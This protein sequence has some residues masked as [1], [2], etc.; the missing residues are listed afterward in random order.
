MKFLLPLLWLVAVTHAADWPQFLGPTR[1]NVSTETNLNLAWPKEGPKILWKTKIGEGWSGPV[2]VSNCVMVFHRVGDSEVLDCFQNTNGAKLW[3]AE[4]PSTYRDDFGFESGPRATPAVDGQRVF[5]F[6]ANGILNAWNLTNGSNLWRVDTRK[7]FSS[8]KGF[9]GIACSPLVEGGAVI[10]NIGG[11]G[12]GVVSFDQATGKV[13]WQTT[14]EEAS[15]SSPTVATIGGQRRIF[16]FGRKHLLALDRDGKLLWEFP[17]TPRIEASVSA[18]TPLVIGEQVFISAS[19]G[20]GAALL[21]VTGARPEVVW[22]GDDSL[23]SHYSSIVHQRG[24]LYGFD[25]RQEQR[26]RLRCVELATGKARWSEER[27][28]AGA[29]LVVGDRLLILTERGELIV[30]PASQEKFSPTA[31]AQILGTDLRAHPALADG[32]FF[33]RDK[34]VLVAVDLRGRP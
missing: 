14:S 3:H 31:R 16:V 30:V 22:S 5:T 23:S 7:Q 2:V 18:A 26:A 11:T 10:L 34:G 4:Y 21:R 6:G 12:A 28:G 9:F 17:W 33:A 32:I 29:I 24:F 8:D 1:D 25:G 15:Y 20:A 27:F 13:L 19:Y